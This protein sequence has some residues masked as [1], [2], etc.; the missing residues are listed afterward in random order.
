MFCSKCGRE[1]EPTEKFCAYCGEPCTEEAQAEL[2]KAY[3][4]STE[5]NTSAIVG[6]ILSFFIPLAGLILAGFGLKKAKELGGKGK[7]LSI[8][9]II[10]SIIG[11]ALNFWLLSMGA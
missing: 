1:L 9:A 8:A 11:W 2:K 3:K 4:A 10:V 6:F 5:K 7:G